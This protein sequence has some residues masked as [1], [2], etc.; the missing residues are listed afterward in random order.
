MCVS[1]PARVVSVEGALGVVATPSGGRRVSL[2]AVPGV[3]VGEYVLVNLG[4]A[5]RRLSPAD[6]QELLETWEAIHASFDHPLA[7]RGGAAGA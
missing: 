7:A 4:V 2:L 6:A 5:V 3:A 1:L